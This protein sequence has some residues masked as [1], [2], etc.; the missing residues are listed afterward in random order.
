MHQSRDLSPE[1]LMGWRWEP[2][3][4]GED[5]NIQQKD[6]SHQNLFATIC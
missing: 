3:L 1:F 6:G 2:G 5:D 4:R